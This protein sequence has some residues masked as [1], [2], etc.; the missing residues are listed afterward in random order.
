MIKF[1]TS[2]QDM[3][4]S[5]VETAQYDQIVDYVT[6][7]SLNLMAVK[8]TNRPEDFLGW[9]NELYNY[10]RYGINMDLLDEKH[11]KPLQ[12]L[13]Q[14]LEKS[15]TCRQVKTS[16][17][18]PWPFLKSFFLDQADRQA[19]AERLRLLN[20][21][22]T[23]RISTL[24]D[25]SDLERLAFAG[26]HLSAHEPAKF[27]FDVEL[28]G[29]TRGAKAL[30][31]LLQHNPSLVD[32]ALSAIPLEGEVSESDYK[33]FV[34]RY[35][36]AFATLDKA[37]AGLF[38]ATRLLAMRRPDVF[39]VLTAAKVDALCQGFGLVKLNATDFSRYWVDIIE[40]LHRQPWFKSAQPEDATE[41]ELWNNRVVLFDLFFFVDKDF[42]EKSNYLKLKNKPVVVRTSTAGRTRTAG[43]IRKKRTKES[44]TEAV[45][46]LLA[47]PD[48]P[49]YL[50][51]KRDSMIAE[52]EKGKSAT[53][54]MQLLRAIFG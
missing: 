27:D 35:T 7:I 11:E 53:E 4:L 41:L 36:A 50:Q 3:R 9:C 10:V 39:M 51:S 20:Y 42:A 25:M 47:E 44:A 6:E 17:I 34:K 23:L 46:R 37:K 30:H 8:V 1:I 54:V 38:A 28:F 21:I 22:S 19:L 49:S 26:K 14:L 33:E 12:K 15:I 29:S 2:P 48:L 16:R 5:D 18:T 31:E 45:D 43:V 40:A 24:A 32:D 13:L 52:V